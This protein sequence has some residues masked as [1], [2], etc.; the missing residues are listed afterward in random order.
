VVTELYS[1]PS[2]LWAVCVLLMY[3]ISRVQ[4]LSHRGALHDDPVVFAA[5]DKVS[6]AVA[7]SAAAVVFW[8]A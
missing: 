1:T 2:A 7:V 5:T 6:W 8:S 3:W 4:I